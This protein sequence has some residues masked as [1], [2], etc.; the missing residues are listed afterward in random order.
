MGTGNR[1]WFFLRDLPVCLPRFFFPL[2]LG[3]R[4]FTEPGLGPLESPPFSVTPELELQLC[5]YGVS[6][7][8]LLCLYSV[9]GGQI[10]DSGWSGVH[11][12]Y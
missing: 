3:T 9:A 6:T 1:T 10:W 2:F 12:T 7:L 8:S 11:F 5:F 4:F